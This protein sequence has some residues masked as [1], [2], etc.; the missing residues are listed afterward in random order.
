M[1][2]YTLCRIQPAHLSGVAEIERLCFPHEPWSEK[3]LLALCEQGGI[4]FVTIEADGTP[5]AYVGMLYAA[6][7]G[8]ITNVA[9]HPDYRRGGRAAAVLEA[10]LSF[11]TQHCSEGVFLEVRPSN[12]A[13][14]QL[15][16]QHGFEQVG[17]RKGFYRAPAEDALILR[18]I[19]TA[20]RA[21]DKL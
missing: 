10:L 2:P 3:S 16:L 20:A 19:P 7:E 12:I 17:R 15:Y 14:L 5:S 11:A 13:A 6:D 18:A 1:Q 21:D 4:G 9:T 8:S